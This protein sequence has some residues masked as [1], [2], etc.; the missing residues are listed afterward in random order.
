[1]LRASLTT[2]RHTGDWSA[3]TQWA[4]QAAPLHMTNRDSKLRDHVHV[5]AIPRV[6]DSYDAFGSGGHPDTLVGLSGKK[7]AMHF[8]E[9]FHMLYFT[10]LPGPLFA[11]PS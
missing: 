8:C 9:S 1:M 7:L 11:P 6:A 10:K 3:D 4:R 5:R 2:L